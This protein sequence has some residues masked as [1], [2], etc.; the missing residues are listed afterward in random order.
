MSNLYGVNDLPGIKLEFDVV[1]EGIIDKSS[2]SLNYSNEDHI[3][4]SLH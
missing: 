1:V 2:F 3:Y 4:T